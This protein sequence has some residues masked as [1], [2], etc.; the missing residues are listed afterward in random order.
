MTNW[1]NL[2][3]EFHLQAHAVQKTNTQD[4]IKHF[5][6]LSYATWASASE[7]TCIVNW[8]TLHNVCEQIQIQQQQKQ[9]QQQKQFF[10]NYKQF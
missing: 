6:E 10:N 2:V 4:K 9:P 1:T 7:G 3:V 8:V 5:T